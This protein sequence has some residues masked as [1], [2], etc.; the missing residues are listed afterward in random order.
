[1]YEDFDEHLIPLSIADPS[2]GGD[3][4]AADHKSHD[5]ILLD[6][7]SRAVIG[8]VERTGPTVVSIRTR[9]AARRAG[10][11]S[12]GT[13]S[14]GEGAGSGVLFTPDGFI[15][16]NH[17]V[18]DQAGE[19]SVSLVDGETYSATC[20][21]TDPETDLA[22]L[23]IS[24]SGFPAARFGDSD[25]LRVGQLVIAIGNPLGFQNTVSTGVVSAL[26]RSLRSRNG[27]LIENVIQTDVSLN[28]GNSGGPLVDS[29]GMVAGIN[30]AMIQMAQGICF[31]I[32][33]NTARYVVSEL[34]RHGRVERPYIGIQARTV[35]VPRRIERILKL[36]AP[37]V[38]EVVLVERG[39]PAWISG[40]QTGD[41]IYAVN[42]ERVS[43]MD[44]LHRLLG[45]HAAGSSFTLSIVRRGSTKELMLSTR[46]R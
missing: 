37:S 9:Q 1:M 31:A 7:Y 22:V 25:A 13:G 5:D 6:A 11:R 36:K 34:V 21:G 2:A 28:P 39:E 26:G 15:L 43:T 33:V 10:S 27:R 38:V 35:P 16:T 24:G 46:G 8:V 44:E 41:F 18:V 14:Q 20:A 45:H 32:P 19:I 12:E 17:H 30:T 42:G 23:R 29:A 40:V 4:A 3:A